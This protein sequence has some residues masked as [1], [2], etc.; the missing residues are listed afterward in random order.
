M[1]AKAL[2]YSR[3][4]TEKQNNKSQIQDLKD[5]S[6][7]KKYEIVGVYEDTISGKSKANERTG[8]NNLLLY[9]EQNEVEHILIWELSRLGRNLLDV[10]TNINDLTAKKINVYSKKENLNTLNEDKTPNPNS[11]L[12]LNLMSSV[13]EYERSTI[14]ER[15][16]RGLLRT[17]KDGKVGGKILLGYKKDENNKYII[18]E[19]EAKTIK[20]IFKLYLEGLSSYAIAIHLNQNNITTKAGKKWSEITVR[21]ILQ[22]SSYMGLKKYNF[23]TVQ[24]PS[25][26]SKSTFTKVQ[27][28]F[29]NKLNLN[30]DKAIYISY[31]KGLVKCGEC[32]RFY[33]QHT[34]QSKNVFAYKCHSEKL[35]YTKQIDKKC[36]NHSVNVNW[37]NSMVY[38][39]LLS[40]SMYLINSKKYNQYDNKINGLTKAE[41]N[42]VEKQIKI[43]E[44]EIKQ[45]TNNLNNLTTYLI[46]QTIT[47]QEYINQKDIL[48]TQIEK[49][50]EQLNNL[51]LNQQQLNST[52]YKTDLKH[53]VTSNTFSEHIK[54]FIQSVTI[55]KAELTDNAEL[56]K[57]IQPKQY[58]R[59]TKV[60]VQTIFKKTYTFYTVKAYPNNNSY[61]Q[62]G[63]G[64]KQIKLID[65]IVQ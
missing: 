10:L 43:Y 50:S 47:E 12:M 52:I 29:K 44:T 40:N 55:H 2:I 33:Y 22:N 58:N 60:E 9:I 3:V 13:A 19:T 45:L 65:S 14:K 23:G 59:L 15:T 20:L 4:S 28:I 64:L 18:D 49:K 6:T 36:G 11:T 26:I 53:F 16:N 7:Y 56:S 30:K 32:G 38:Y 37:L 62:Q 63:K 61:Q 51:L 54:T 48:S 34:K 24:I 25:I 5:Y 41:L 31:L 42:K 39:A 35:A 8:F 57:V 21:Q 17:K 27:D 1:K 46:N